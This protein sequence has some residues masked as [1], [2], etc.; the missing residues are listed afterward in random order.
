MRNTYTAPTRQ[1]ELDNAD[2]ES[3]VCCCIAPLPWL[4]GAAFETR[5]TPVAELL[6]VVPRL[7]G[8]TLEARV[9]F[10]EL[11]PWPRGT[12]HEARVPVVEIVP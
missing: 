4:T 1:H 5:T 2:Q 7:R 8:T 10:A 6:I 12:A 3:T 11:G 9:P